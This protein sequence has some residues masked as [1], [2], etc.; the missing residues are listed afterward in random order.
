MLAAE[1]AELKS[2]V[3]QRQSKIAGRAKFWT[4]HIT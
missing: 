3:E 1:N 2:Q 4:Y